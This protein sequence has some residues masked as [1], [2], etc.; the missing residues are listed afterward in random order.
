VQLAA[1]LLHNDGNQIRELN[2]VIRLP[3][4]VEIPPKAI[5]VHGITHEYTQAFGLPLDHAMAKLQGMIVDCDE[6]NGTGRIIA[7]NMQFDTHIILAE[8]CHC[9][10]PLAPFGLLRPFCTMVALTSHMKLPFASSTRTDDRYKWPSLDEAYHYMFP[11][12][13]PVSG[14]ARHSAMGDCLMT[15]DVYLAGRDRNLWP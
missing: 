4:S 10:M 6:P 14:G 9:H 7:H 13:P 5:A 11:D 3:H 2:C 8:L 1:L 15:R 12:R